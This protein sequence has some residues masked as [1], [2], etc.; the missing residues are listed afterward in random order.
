MEYLTRLLL[1]LNEALLS[2]FRPLIV[3]IGCSF[4][5]NKQPVHFSQNAPAL[6]SVNEIR[7]AWRAVSQA[8][9]SQAEVRPKRRWAKRAVSQACAAG[10]V[11]QGGSMDR[12]A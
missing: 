2:G 7:T 3:T 12:L 11:G 9:V 5:L 10:P 8:E 1:G 6:H 4:I